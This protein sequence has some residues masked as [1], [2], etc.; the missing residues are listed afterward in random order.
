VGL[1]VFEH[2]DIDTFY[3]AKQNNTQQDLTP[4]VMKIPCEM[5]SFLIQELAS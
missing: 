1:N 3:G 5:P 2:L 4:R